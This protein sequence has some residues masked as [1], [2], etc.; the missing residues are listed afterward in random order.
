MGGVLVLLMVMSMLGVM[1]YGGE[2]S[3]ALEYNGQKF[4]LSENIL[5]TD[6]NGQQE[7]F[8]VMPQQVTQ[9]NK[10]VD[11]AQSL[12]TQKI[13][14]TFNPNSNPG[15]LPY[16]DLIRQDFTRNFKSQVISGVTEQS[17]VYQ[18]PVITCN[19][20][21]PEIPVIEFRNSLNLSIE[22]EGNC[23][24]YNGNLADFLKL[25]DLTIYTY[26]GIITE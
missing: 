15:D 18:I 3:D 9:I 11:F 26:H 12:Q 25:R 13:I 21:T 23:L 16:L 20:S 10:P 6:I 1:L 14:L 2:S 8:F 19:D 5:L 7:M 24:I 4:T 22:K 17:D